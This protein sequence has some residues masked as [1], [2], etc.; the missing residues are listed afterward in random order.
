[1]GEWCKV[2]VIVPESFR[3]KGGHYAPGVIAKGMLYISGQLPIDHA[4]G[5]VVEGGFAAQVRAA[6]ANVE[7]VLTAAGL[8]RADVAQCRVYLPDIALWDEADQIYAAFFGAHRPARAV[9]P[10]RALH[11]GALI[12][13]EAVAEMGEA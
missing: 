5:K 8:T 1:M 4:T 6:L 12:E 2:Q 11:H 3:K 13:I 7:A 10:T 9:V